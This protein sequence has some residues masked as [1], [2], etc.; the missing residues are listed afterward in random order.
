M[1]NKAKMNNFLKYLA[2][3]T[4]FMTF[5]VGCKTTNN[6]ANNDNEKA[7]LVI[8]YYQTPGYSKTAPEY[9]IELYSNRQMHLIA[10]KN[11][12]KEGKY[13]RRLTKEEYKQLVDA[14][15]DA[16]FFDFKDEYTDNITD[17]PTRYI[18]FT[19]NGKSKKIKDYYGAPEKLGELELMVR[20]YLDR[21]GWSKMTW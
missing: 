10:T 11:L 2:A 14:F 9:T 3:F 16:D 17:L 1:K 21:V 18:S 20:S 4:L 15:V 19:H 7:S 13:I 12:D 6:V 8:S 5:L